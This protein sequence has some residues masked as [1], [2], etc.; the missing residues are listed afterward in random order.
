VR[1][2]VII[3]WLGEM[4]Y[5]ALE[6]YWGQRDSVCPLSRSLPDFMPFATETN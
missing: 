2:P 5:P 1:E 6:G 4:F 3:H